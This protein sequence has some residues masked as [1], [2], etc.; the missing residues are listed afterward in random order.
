MRKGKLAEPS[1]GFQRPGGTH[2]PPE[3]LVA[4][5]TPT[6]APRTACEPARWGAIGLV[7]SRKDKFPPIPVSVNHRELRKMD[8]PPRWT[9]RINLCRWWTMGTWQGLCPG[10]QREG[11]ARMAAGSPP[12]VPTHLLWVAGLPTQAC[13]RGPGRAP[14]A[15][16][17]TAVWSGLHGRT[18]E[19]RP[20][21][22]SPGPTPAAEVALQG[23]ML[24]RGR[25]EA[26]SAPVLSRAYCRGPAGHPGDT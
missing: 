3:R 23:H 24:G 1:G 4:G 25:A 20:G 6:P 2:C 5:S 22:G 16:A 8:S 11:T 13:W 26:L 12:G 14:L 9:V 17:G 10:R 15:A 18:V 19:P 7:R 21:A